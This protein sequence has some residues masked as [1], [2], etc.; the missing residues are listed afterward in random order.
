MADGFG[1][2]LLMFVVAVLICLSSI[3][4]LFIDLLALC[5]VRHRLPARDHDGAFLK[6]AIFVANWRGHDVLE[7]MV[8]GNLA[9][10]RETNVQLVLGVYPNDNET[11]EIAEQL[12]A[13]HPQRVRVVVNRV[14]GPTSKGQMLNEMF[15]QV[16]VGADA[17]ELVV[18][19]DSEDVIDPRSFEIYNAYA[20][21]YDFI[22]IPVFSLDCRNRSL[23]GATYMDEFAERHTREMV[24]RD[25]LGA[26]IPSAGVGTCMTKKLVRHFL[27]HRGQ[28]L[29]TGCVTE[30]YILG[31]ETKCAGFR[32]AFA[33]VSE[34][35]ARYGEFVATREFFPQ[36]FW[37][38]VRQKTRW[39]FGIDFEAMHRLGWRADPWDFYFFLRDRKGMI[40][41]F[42]PP[43]SIVLIL[44][45]FLDTYDLD[46]LP[47]ELEPT[48]SLVLWVN[49]AAMNLRLAFRVLAF[50]QV[51]GCYNIAGVLLRWAVAVAV[52][53]VAVL[54]HGKSISSSLGLPHARSSGPRRS[55]RSQS[56]SLTSEVSPAKSRVEGGWVMINENA[57][58]RWC[59]VQH[60]A[61]TIARAERRKRQERPRQNRRFFF[62]RAKSKFARTDNNPH[63]G[64][65]R[66]VSRMSREFHHGEAP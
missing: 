42:L 15:R 63:C 31:I 3:D 50:R 59:R 13:R 25:A 22:Q 26:A 46:Q 17:T 18:L 34:S 65:T 9:Q 37:A 23:V 24:V 5:I 11:R 56:I 30:D 53:A 10:I 12:A 6:T 64:S 16:F 32:A 2:V 38:A 60:C 66:A 49:V 4:D 29:A 19:H 33:A 52:N 41:N 45:L 7:K 39:V 48:L 61:R 58:V 51:Y 62:W 8:E 40:T 28:V 36:G 55:M 21:N 44:L 27:R 1:L 35:A 47:P 57:W 20:E 54:R 43:I 14:A